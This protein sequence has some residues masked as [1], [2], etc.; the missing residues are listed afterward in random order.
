MQLA[1]CCPALALILLASS[2]APALALDNGLGR[3]PSMGYNTWYSFFENPTEGACKET[4]ALLQTLG[5]R[6]AGYEYL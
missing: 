4:I 2:F 6:A 1:W 5:L 3:T